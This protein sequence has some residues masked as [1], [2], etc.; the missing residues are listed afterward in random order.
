MP[1]WRRFTEEFLNRFDGLTVSPAARDLSRAVFLLQA[2]DD[3]EDDELR[4]S[5]QES[6]AATVRSLASDALPDAEV[7]FDFSR[8]QAK[9]ASAV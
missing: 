3:L 9:E 7:E 6:L 8:Q 1:P 4:G 2:I 5:L